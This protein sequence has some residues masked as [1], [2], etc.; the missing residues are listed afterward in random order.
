LKV[1]VFASVNNEVRKASKC[2]LNTAH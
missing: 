2:I 1:I